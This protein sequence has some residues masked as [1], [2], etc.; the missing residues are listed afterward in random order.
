MDI[1]ET[2]Q[3]I[4]VRLASLER[5]LLGLETRMKTVSQQQFLANEVLQEF[6]FA[7]LYKTTQDAN[8]LASLII[9]LEKHTPPPETSERIALLQ[10]LALISND[11]A[12]HLTNIYT[13]L[14]ALMQ[15][16]D[17]SYLPHLYNVTTQE[18][19]HLATFHA[20][21]CQHL[22]SKGLR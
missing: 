4:E 14:D 15:S 18:I 6:A 20:L 16:H 11:L 9:V 7:R 8:E 12:S 2:T 17:D 3:K 21:V 19:T 5:K 13:F 10:T 22:E 1:A